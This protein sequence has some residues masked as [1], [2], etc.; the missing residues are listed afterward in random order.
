MPKNVINPITVAAHLIIDIKSIIKKLARDNQYILEFGDFHAHGASNVIPSQA[1]FQGTLRTLDEDFRK[2]VHNTLFQQLKRI[3]KQHNASCIIDLKKGYPVL[4]NNPLLT[5]K[6][7]M[8]SKQFLTEDVVK[9]L[10]IRMAS[11]D[12]SYF[13]QACPSCFF[14]LGV[15]NSAKK[16]N[17]LVHT[18]YFNIDEKS[19]E[20]GVGLM[21]Y[22]TVF[23]L[24]D[25]KKS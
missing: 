10:D 20:I 9:D 24:L 17:H 3:V 18:P 22:L 23:N 2:D 7:K 16:I 6:C 14:R 21:S 25:Q 1:F 8:L 19:L 5:Q 11:E 12:F 4:Y 13:S 15:A